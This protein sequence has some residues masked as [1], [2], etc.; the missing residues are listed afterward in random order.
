[1]AQTEIKILVLAVTIIVIVLAATLVVFFMYFQKK[2]TIYILKQRETQQR[3][4]KEINQS[5]LE[6]Q[7]QALQNISWEIHDN[8]GQLL[9][10][11]KMQ[12]N[13][14]K[15]SLPEEQKNS[16][17]ETSGIVGK[18]LEELRGLS[19]SLNPATIKNKGLLESIK[20]EVDR[21][22]RLNVINAELNIKGEEFSLSNEKEIIL[23]RILQEFC[24][25]TLKYAKATSLIIELNFSKKK[26][27]IYASDNGKG[28]DLKDDS[29]EIGIGIINIKSRA[30]LIGAKLTLNSEIEKGTKLYISC[31]K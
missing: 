4:E 18:S 27:E 1:M 17:S 10:V 11:A 9:S 16:I 12:L 5:R 3:F 21:F 13:M 15:H 25:N 22:N 2:K 30:E 19:K 29:K 26:L 8:I 28:F 31:S 24:N 7:E 23:F 20:F 14:L 6:I